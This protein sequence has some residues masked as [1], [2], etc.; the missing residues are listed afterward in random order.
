MLRFP[1]F[2]ELTAPLCQDAISLFGSPF[3]DLDD[4]E[5]ASCKLLVRKAQA[6][7]FALPRAQSLSGYS[8]T[9]HLAVWLVICLETQKAKKERVAKPQQNR[10]T[11]Y[12][13][14]SSN[15]V[16]GPFC[17]S[18]TC[19]G[20]SG[21]LPG[22]CQAGQV[23]RVTLPALAVLRLTLLFHR[24]RLAKSNSHKGPICSFLGLIARS[25]GGLL[26]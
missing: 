9:C 10:T 1:G 3:K 8:G 7:R 23:R 16:I 13:I 15:S 17:F 14:P 2:V 11:A 24:I 5:R 25:Q 12:F 21:W 19:L 18:Q 20:N 22:S 6:R 4:V 26:P